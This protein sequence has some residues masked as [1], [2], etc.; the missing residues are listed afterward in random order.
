MCKLKSA[1][2]LKDRI[3]V[4]DYDSHNEMLRELGIE[5][6]YIGASKTFVRAELSPKDGDEFSPVE[7]WAFKVDQD[8]VPEWFSQDEYKP[9]MVI[10]VKAWA[11]EHIHVNK[12]GLVIDRGNGHRIKGGKNIV[13]RGS[14]QVKYIGGSAQVEYIGDSAQVEYIRDSAQ[15]EYIRDSAVLSYYSTWENEKKLKICG[16][17][18]VRDM[19]KRKIYQAGGFEFVS[20]EEEE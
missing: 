6:D 20:V 8:I 15:V 12:D 18:T 13:V 16:M 10:A 9:R 1:I 4:P 2:I 7:T 14:A 17:A 5:D 3:F 19:K 11:D